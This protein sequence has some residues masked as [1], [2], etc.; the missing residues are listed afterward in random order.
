MGENSDRK[1]VMSPRS[2]NSSEG[3][4]SMSEDMYLF[5]CQSELL[6][7][8]L[9]RLGLQKQVGRRDVVTVK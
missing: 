8:L 3:K 4:C 5:G 2:I 9:E 1:Q 7:H 6:R